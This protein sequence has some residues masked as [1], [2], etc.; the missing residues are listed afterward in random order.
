MGTGEFWVRKSNRALMV[1]DDAQN[2][3]PRQQDTAALRE[4]IDRL[5]T[6]KNAV[7]LAHYYQR[8]EVQEIADFVGDSLGLSQQALNTNASVIV[9]AGVYFMAETAHILN[10]GKKVLLPDLR[11]GCSLADSC[12]AESLLIAKSLYPRHKVVSYINCSAEVK[13][14]SDIICTSANA[15]KVIRSVP[16]DEQILFVPDRNLG[17]YLQQETGREM[18]LWDGSCVVHDNFAIDKILQLHID[19]PGAVLVAHPEAETPILKAAAFVGS[20]SGMIDF[21]RNDPR[22]CFIV[23]TEA[24]ILH[25]MKKE[26]PGKTLIPAPVFSDNT[27]ACSE[28]GFMKYIT[29]QSIADCLEDERH[30]ITVPPD[31]AQKAI[32]PIQRMLSIS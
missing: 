19:H 14:L 11:S 29:L 7:I 15:V 16:D 32:V 10:P 28:C 20:T 27:C 12:T 1:A 30:E 17:N 9:F 5:R 8:P 25:Q 23:A 13:A 31:V 24:G 22:H 3:T 26:V 2:P 18:V 21:V 4:K 6:E